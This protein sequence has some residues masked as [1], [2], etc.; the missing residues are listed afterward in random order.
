MVDSQIKGADLAAFARW[1]RDDHP[2]IAKELRAAARGAAKPVLAAERAAVKSLTFSTTVDRRIAGLRVGSRT[3]QGSGRGGGSGA[4]TRAEARGTT[5]YAVAVST[6]RRLVSAK[7][8]ARNRRGAGLRDTIARGMRIT[9]SDRGKEAKATVKATSTAMPEG[10]KNL[11]RLVNY[12]RWRHPVFPKP[13]TSRKQWTWV[14]KKP[15]RPGWWWVTANKEVPATRELFERA[16]ADI[17]DK[18]GRSAR[19]A[20]RLAT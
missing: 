12:G 19:R 14:Y 11:P 13:G 7:T 4:K 18:V 5:S 20:V 8:A 9:Y 16:L 15:S 17:E 10:Q 6:G 3:V 2:D 1:L